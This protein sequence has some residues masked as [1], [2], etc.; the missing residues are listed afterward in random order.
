MRLGNIPV[1]TLLH[2]TTPVVKEFGVVSTTEEGM[3]CAVRGDERFCVFRVLREEVFHHYHILVFVGLIP[4]GG[5]SA[6]VIRLEQRVSPGRYLQSFR[7]TMLTPKELSAL[8]VSKKAPFDFHLPVFSSSEWR[9]NV[10]DGLLVQIAYRS[11]LAFPKRDERGTVITFRDRSLEPQYRL[12]RSTPKEL[13]V[14]SA[15]SY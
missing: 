7:V 13:V 14:E 10:Q 9:R 11:V 3:I 1:W 2:G 6:K 12:I 4:Q 5:V 15:S 8:E